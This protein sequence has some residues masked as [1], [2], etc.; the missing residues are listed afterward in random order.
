[1]L[2]AGGMGE[3]YAA[4]DTVLGDTV[5][6]K[7]IAVGADADERAS[8]RIKAEVQLARRVTHRNVC[9]V[10]DVGFHMEP[11]RQ[12]APGT[13][14]IP[15]FTMELLRGETLGQRIRR[16]GPLS[17]AEVMGLLSQIARGL[18]AAH[19]V[20]VIH[21]DLKSDNIMLVDEGADTRVV[22]TDFGLA[23]Q[24]DGRGRP[25]AVASCIAGTLAYMAPEQFG[26]GRTGRATDI[27]ALGV[28]LF[29]LLTGQRPF[30]PKSVAAAAGT[31]TR[32]LVPELPRELRVP[33]DWGGII[34]RCL[35]VRPEER[36][37]RAREVVDALEA[38]Y[39]SSGRERRRARSPSGP[40]SL[41]VIACALALS[42]AMDAAT[43]PSAGGRT[44]PPPSPSRPAPSARP[45]PE[46]PRHAESEA[47]SEPSPAVAK[48][49][50]PRPGR[51]RVVPRKLARP[52][53]QPIRQKA[54]EVGS[55]SSN[56]ELIAPPGWR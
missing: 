18:D 56:D 35:R 7:T 33:G 34:G 4:L 40:A 38:S 45:P 3:V 41:K 11:E 37:R 36:Y 53:S 10:F 47:S 50:P 13:A 25:E 9:R 14:P 43:P 39:S 55:E 29:E 49:A 46:T 26:S 44:L 5:A 24:L 16:L 52:P 17:T 27:Y 21:T 12:H 51:S 22:I 15:F 31:R 23:T 2:G 28:I 20:G 30:D 54:R 48:K 19:E 6:L 32:L 8:A 42:I 1:M